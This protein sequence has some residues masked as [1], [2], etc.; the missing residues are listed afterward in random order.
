MY[1]VKKALNHNAIVAV[2]TEKAQEYLILGKGIGFGKKVTEYVTPR[3]EDTVY[4][5]TECTERGASDNIVNAV[6][7]ECL[8]IADEIL[9]I[10]EKEFGSIDRKI[11]FPLADHI[12]F[13]IKRI[14]NNEQISN[15]LTD[16]IRILFHSEYKVAE[17]IK[18][19]LKDRMDVDIDEHEI[20]YVALHIHSAIDTHNVAQSMTIA[21]GVRQCISM[22]ESETGRKINVLSISYNRLMNHIKYMI[23][24]GIQGEK[25][26]LNL[27]DYMETK[28]PLEY[29]MA[30]SI[31]ESIGKMLNIKFDSSEIGYLAMH[32]QRVT[33]GELD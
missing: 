32:I 29:N 8:E 17:N 19:L 5:M 13:A 1:R 10:A 31:S 4:S 15:P 3:Q 27:N 12:E 7:P 25:I 22:V 21:Q 24:R 2:D 14:K 6:S 20:G 28:F 18:N 9:N 16:D 23:A 33:S 26:K 30:V 11:L